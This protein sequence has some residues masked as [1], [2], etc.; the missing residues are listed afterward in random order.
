MGLKVSTPDCLCADCGKKVGDNAVRCAVC[1]SYYRE[2]ENLSSEHKLCCGCGS[3][4]R[5]DLCT[6]CLRTKTIQRALA[7]RGKCALCGDANPVEFLDCAACQGKHV[8]CKSCCES[9]PTVSILP[10]TLLRF[11]AEC[12]WR[13]TCRTGPYKFLPKKV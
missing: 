2:R 12:P 13:K 5:G 7:S 9:H 8:L 10:D 3:R 1:W 6:R 4:S 11:L